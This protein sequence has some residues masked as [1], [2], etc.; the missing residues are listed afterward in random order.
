MNRA[1]P[2][3]DGSSDQEFSH[4]RVLSMRPSSVAGRTLAGCPAVVPEPISTDVN[5]GQLRS[6]PTDRSP[7]F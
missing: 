2:L 4:S 7:R 3:L 5:D 6:A 1:L